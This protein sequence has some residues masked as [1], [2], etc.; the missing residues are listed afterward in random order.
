MHGW[1][2][3]KLL[4]LLPDRMLAAHP[5][6]YVGDPDALPMPSTR[7]PTTKPPEADSGGSRSWRAYAEAASSVLNYRVTS[8]SP[9]LIFATR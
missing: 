4:H 3:D 9:E 1:P 5:K 6:L 8:S 7:A 2:Q